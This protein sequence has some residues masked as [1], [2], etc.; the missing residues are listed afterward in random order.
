MRELTIEETEEVGGGILPVV[1]FAVAVV[2]HMMG[3]S[4]VAGWAVSS[5]GLITSTVGLAYYFD[6]K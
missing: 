5:I 3:F 4:G 1:G 6:H 2:G